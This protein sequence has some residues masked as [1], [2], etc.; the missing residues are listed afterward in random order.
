MLFNLSAT[1][2]L[3]FAFFIGSVSTS[4]SFLKTYF[5]T[6]WGTYLHWECYWLATAVGST[7]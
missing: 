7:I 5:I 3:M 6:W 1:Y 4:L 2:L